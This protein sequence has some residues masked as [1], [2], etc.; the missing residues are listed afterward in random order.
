[1]FNLTFSSISYIVSFPSKF[2]F[3]FCF[4][5][6][7][8]CVCVV[9]FHYCVG[10]FTQMFGGLWLTMHIFLTALLTYTSHTIV[11]THLKCTLQ[12]FVVYSQSCTAITTIK[13]RIF[14]SPQKETLDPLVVIPHFPSTNLS[15]PCSWASSRK[16]LIYFPFLYICLSGAFHISGLKICGLLWLSSFT[17]DIFKIHP[18]LQHVLKHHSFLLL[19]NIPL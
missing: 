13:F 18:M 4:L 2:C 7:C 12:C 19:N 6:F 1:M 17:Y 15:P 14:S 16:S 8:M 11:F 9:C 10:G 5:G 3:V